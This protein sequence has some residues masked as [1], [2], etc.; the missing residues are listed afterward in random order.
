MHG[1]FKSPKKMILSVIG[2]ILLIAVLI[3]SGLIIYLTQY[4]NPSDEILAQAGIVEK[5]AQVGDINFNYAEGPDNGPPLLLLHAQLLDWYTYSLVLPELSEHFHVYA[6][7]YP[8]HGKTTTPQDYPMTANQ[9]GSDLA[10]FIETVIGQPVFVAGN[11]SGGLLT[12]WL[13]ANRPDL[14]KAAVLEDPP[15][16]ASE[17]PQI[18]ETIAYKSFTT[19]H[20][21]IEE[22][23]QGDFLDYWIDNSGNFFKTYTGPFSQDLIKFAVTT[24]KNANP[25]QAVEIAFVPATVQEMLRGLHYY[26]PSFGN[27]FYTG[28]WNEDF[29]HAEALK[30]ISCPV[31][32]IQANF[33]YQTDGTLD[34]AMSLEMADRA[35]SLIN[36]CTYVRIDAGHVTNLE[37]PDQYTQILTDFFL[38]HQ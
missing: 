24:Y 5:Q 2:T 30:K 21:A 36:D 9:I 34:G 12:T 20:T 28:S 29:D 38:S 14:V 35:V 4:Q 25:D 15:L 8:G 13:A 27:A 11:S 6:V 26:D 17:Y 37:V 33:T 7:D 23:Y 32:L 1:I 18:K 10:A 16:F 3:V 19:S 22:G 31:L